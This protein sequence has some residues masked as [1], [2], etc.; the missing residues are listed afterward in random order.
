MTAPA[1]WYP[2]PAEFRAPD[3]PG[4]VVHR[5]WDGSSWTA[6][7]GCGPADLPPSWGRPA[8]RIAARSAPP[9]AVTQPL[10]LPHTVALRL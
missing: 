1:G 9:G 8:A 2:S 7:V 3:G 5:W 4:A 6:W 10:A